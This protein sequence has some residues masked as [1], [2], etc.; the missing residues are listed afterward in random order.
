MTF[1][2]AGSMLPV[3]KLSHLLRHELADAVHVLTELDL[4]LVNLG[5]QVFKL[6]FKL[7]G[8]AFLVVL[9]E[10]F[11]GSKLNLRIF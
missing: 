1:L 5:S 3:Y 2:L 11:H 4:L 10:L 8:V 9:H 7:H 6:A